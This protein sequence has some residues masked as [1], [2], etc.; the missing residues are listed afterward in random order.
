[1][2]AANFAD[3]LTERILTTNSR[4]CVG[5]DPSPEHFPPELAEMDNPVAA[6]ARFGEELIGAVEREAAVIKFQ[7]AFYE[8]HGAPGVGALARHAAMAR[9]ARLITILDCKRGDIGN[10]M[11][12]YC[13]AYV[14]PGAP[15]E[16]D[17]VTLTP[18]LGA[19][20]LAPFNVCAAEHGK[21]YFVVVKSSNPSTSDVQDVR[22]EDGRPLYHRVAE[23]TAAV[24]C[25]LVGAE[26]YSAAG[27][28]V[29]ATYPEAVA[30]LREVMPRQF[31][32]LPGVGAQ[33]GDPK[34]LGAAFDERGLGGLVASSRGIAAAWR[35]REGMNWR[36]A[37]R[38]AV[39]ELNAAVNSILSTP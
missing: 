6:I 20:G 29:G 31:F 12:A 17:A 2:T 16:V 13:D 15:V 27:A 14:A 3:R 37:A 30:E 22:M 8:R 7:A 5:C 1:M 28:V 25:H 24:G 39:R 10:T 18:Y 34:M 19:D 21:G 35:E 26:G 4:I 9:D 38:E 33:G 36:D 11:R 23:M 32:L